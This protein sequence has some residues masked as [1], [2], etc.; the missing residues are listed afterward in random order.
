MK[1]IVVVG[2]GDGIGPQAKECVQPLDTG[3]G[4]RFSSMTAAC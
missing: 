3:A 4:N 2:F 1:S